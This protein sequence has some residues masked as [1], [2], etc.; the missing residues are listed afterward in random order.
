MERRQFLKV[1]GQGG[2]IGIFHRMKH[3][4]NLVDI[5][6]VGLVR[7]QELGQLE[8]IAR[9]GHLVGVL[10]AAEIDRRL[11]CDQAR[12][13]DIL[14]EGL[15]KLDHGNVP[16]LIGFSADICPDGRELGQTVDRF[17]DHF[18]G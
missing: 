10:A 12:Q 5:I 11:G 14:A 1:I 13:R 17:L 15:V 7:R 16:A 8:N 18:W 6:L 2:A 4:V 9:R 3:K